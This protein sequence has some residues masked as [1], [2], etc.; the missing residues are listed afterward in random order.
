MLTVQPAKGIRH[1]L[2]MYLGVAGNK[3]CAVCG[4]VSITAAPDGL[5]RERKGWIWDFAMSVARKRFHR[6]EGRATCMNR[7][8]DYAVQLAK[9]PDRVAAIVGKTYTELGDEHDPEK[10]GHLC[11]D[12]AMELIRDL[13]MNLDSTLIERN[14]NK[15]LNLPPF[16]NRPPRSYRS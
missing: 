8:E 5:R 6:R 14:K 12:T 3:V 7:A 10:P 11:D 4:A 2:V 9:L 1:E 13:L 16:V 15:R